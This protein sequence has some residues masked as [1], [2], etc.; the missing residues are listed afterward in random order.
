MQGEIAIQRLLDAMNKFNDGFKREGRTSIDTV[1]D[2][3]NLLNVARVATEESVQK[4]L[5]DVEKIFV[6]LQQ[7]VPDVL[8]FGR[9][10]LKMASEDRKALLLDLSLIHI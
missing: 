6:F 3:A 1:G 4:A 8:P 2:L 5:R 9:T 7:D 10:I